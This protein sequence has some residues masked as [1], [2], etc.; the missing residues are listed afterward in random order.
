MPQIWPPRIGEY[1]IGWQSD[2]LGNSEPIIAYGKVTNWLQPG[3]KHVRATDA[4]GGTIYMRYAEG[5]VLGKPLQ[6]KNPEWQSHDGDSSIPATLFGVVVKIDPHYLDLH[7]NSLVYRINPVKHLTRLMW[8]S[9]AFKVVRKNSK[10]YYSNEVPGANA[11]DAVI[12]LEKPPE[13]CSL[14]DFHLRD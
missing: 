6:F 7:A 5:V 12:V 1:A 11:W 3:G 4:Q 14:Y 9:E 8:G 10:G 13:L 2:S